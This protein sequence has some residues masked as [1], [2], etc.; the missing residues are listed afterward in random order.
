MTYN[1]WSNYETWV[2]ALWIDNEQGSYHYA[3]E[4][5]EEHG[6]DGLEDGSLAQS[7]RDWIEDSQPELPASVYSDLLGAAMSEINWQEIANGYR[8]HLEYIY[9]PDDCEDDLDDSDDEDD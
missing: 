9:E 1:G 3:N 6:F 2:T 5:A 8:G 4:L 7:L